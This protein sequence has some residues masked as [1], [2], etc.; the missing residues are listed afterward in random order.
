M[1]LRLVIR[2][3]IQR[4]AYAVAASSP[5][6]RDSTAGDSRLDIIRKTL[7]PVGGVDTGS[8]PTGTYHA[9]HQ[10]RL[11]HVLGSNPE[12]HETI[13]R[14]WKTHQRQVRESRKSALEA[15]HAEMVRACEALKQCDERL[16]AQAMVKPDIRKS[17]S[18]APLDPQP[19]GGKTSLAEKR[20]KAARI[21]GLFPREWPVA[22]ETWGKERWYKGEQAVKE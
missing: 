2:P 7:Y 6:D 4:R 14:A 10:A 16:Y 18:S 5:K 12:V 11:A 1:S 8:S 19:E 3:I 21:E 22:R 13:E 15:K 20:K 9:D 17:S